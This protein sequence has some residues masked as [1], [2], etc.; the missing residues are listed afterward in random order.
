MFGFP[1]GFLVVV[2]V[3]KRATTFITGLA[4]DRVEFTTDERVGHL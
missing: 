4:W 3:G 2:Q 1:A